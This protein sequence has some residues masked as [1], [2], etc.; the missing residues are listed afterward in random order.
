[1]RAVLSYCIIVL[2]A[3]SDDGAN[4]AN[5]VFPELLPEWTVP[6]E[7][8]LDGGV[9]KDGIPS[10]DTPRFSPASAVNPAFN[11]ELVLGIVSDDVVRAYPIPIL[12][13]HEV[14]ND[15]FARQQVS[16]TYCP[17]TGTG[18]G[19]QLPL[20]NGGS[21]GVSGLLFNSNLMPY[22]RRTNSTWSQMKFECVNGLLRGRRPIT[23][24][25]VE[26]SFKTW[27]TTF[28]DSEVMN[29]NTGFDRRY[30]FYPYG[31]YRTN[32]ERL[33]F[34]VALTDD[35]L[36]PK[37]R[38]R[39]VIVDDKVKVYPFMGGEE[40]I[41]VFHD[42]FEEI[43]LVLSISK[44]HNFISAFIRPEGHQFSP[45]GKG[46]PAILVDQKGNH[47]NLA[48]MVISGPQQGMSLETPLS[49]MG[50]WLAWPSF[51]TDIEI[52]SK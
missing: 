36:P 45:P 11:D 12:D 10:I 22:D 39:G 15:H 23:Y 46:L 34:P 48:G 24:T 31:D 3:C 32:Q 7:L 17:L 21:F 35:R 16:I 28:P 13:W 33:I 37:E 44:E 41:T 27:K 4:N 1:M 38:V 47:Y 42:D 40:G 6:R 18:I 49:L 50:F 2:F 14:V 26:T 30:S 8:V 43:P 19:W 25:L 9:G 52:Y 51:Y 5:D 29:A 20:G